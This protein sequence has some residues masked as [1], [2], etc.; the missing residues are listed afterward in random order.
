MF[1][2]LIGGLMVLGCLGWLVWE[3]AESDTRFESTCDYVL[4]TPREEP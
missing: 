1:D 4:G 2:I 3:W